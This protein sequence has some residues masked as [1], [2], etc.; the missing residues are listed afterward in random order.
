MPNKG[1]GEVKL[2]VGGRSF[3]LRPSFE[4][5]TAIETATD[6]SVA[7]LI[8]GLGSTTKLTDLV[9]VLWVAATRSK[10]RDVPPIEKLGEQILGEFGYAGAHTIVRDFLITGSSSDK[11]Y[12]V[13]QKEILQAEEA[14]ETKDADPSPPPEE[15]KP[16]EDANA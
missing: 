3:I 2:E 8:V 16:G 4:L 15:E 1:R 14:S 12:E 11:Q 13:I 5:M 7:E 10:N 9:T 6:K